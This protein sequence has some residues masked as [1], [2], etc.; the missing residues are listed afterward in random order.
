MVAAAAV[1]APATAPFASFVAAPADVGGVSAAAAA[2]ADPEAEA[3]SSRFFSAKIEW[4]RFRRR[5]LQRPRPP[6]PPPRASGRPRAEVKEEGRLLARSV[7]RSVCG[8]ARAELLRTVGSLEAKMVALRAKR[9]AM[10]ITP[11][12][13]EERGSGMEGNG[14]DGNEQRALNGTMASMAR[15][16]AGGLLQGEAALCLLP[17]PFCRPEVEE[18]ANSL[19]QNRRKTL[20]VKS[21]GSEG[22]LLLCAVKRLRGGK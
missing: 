15:G 2:A 6:P 5:S 17:R 21:R 3:R 1:A 13:E 9:C 20:A 11:P 14:R 22:P 18:A 4:D 7:G 16:G 10:A 19:S 12:R 8:R